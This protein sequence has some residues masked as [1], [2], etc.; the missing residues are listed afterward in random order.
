MHPKIVYW[1]ITDI[2]YYIIGTS[3]NV[4][5]LKFE[6]HQSYCIFSTSNCLLQA[7]N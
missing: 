3:E 2:E 1:K 5:T 4:S 6:N 7:Y